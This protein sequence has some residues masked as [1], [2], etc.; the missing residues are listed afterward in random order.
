MRTRWLVGILL[1][2]A[3]DYAGAGAT[4]APAPASPSS[5]PRSVILTGTRTVLESGTVRSGPAPGTYAVT[6]T[7]RGL[8]SRSLVYAA[9][10]PVPTSGIQPLTE[11]VRAVVAVG[12]D[13]PMILS[14]TDTV[15]GIDRGAG[16]T[17][18][19][20]DLRTVT[21]TKLGAHRGAVERIVEHGFGTNGGS[22]A[23]IDVTRTTHDDGSFDETGSIR[24][25]EMHLLHVGVDF[26][27]TAHDQ[28]P[29]FG[30]R[31]VTTLAPIGHGP[32]ATIPVSVSTQGRTIGDVPIVRATYTVPVWF[33]PQ[34]LP[35]EVAHVRTARAPLDAECRYPAGTRALAVHDRRRQV[36][37]TGT[38]TEVVSDLFYD[39]TF[40]PLCRID[41]TSTTW[42]DVTTGKQTG[43]RSDRLVVSAAP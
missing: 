40:A 35:T 8:G 10:M 5:P 27:A 28:T 11:T 25:S 1:C 39:A 30:L 6:E 21:A 32:N 9:P 29:G 2:V 24:S 17:Y 22:F 36:D 12:G 34:A 41:R 7:D 18:T 33:A 23:S 13:G 42:F 15:S 31:D 14:A 4:T 26:G 37:P 16:Q 43:V 38:I 20:N 3:S 19:V